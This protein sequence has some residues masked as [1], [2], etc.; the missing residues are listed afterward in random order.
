MYQIYQ[1]INKQLNKALNAAF[2]KEAL[3]AK[4]AGESLNP[5]LIHILFHSI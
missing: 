1:E 3:A 5:Q 2:A 4:K